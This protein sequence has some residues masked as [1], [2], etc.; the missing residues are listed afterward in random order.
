MII[1]L[2]CSI[3]YIL[4][5]ISL[6]VKYLF[7]NREM[8]IE[9]YKDFLTSEAALRITYISSQNRVKWKKLYTLDTRIKSIGTAL[10]SVLSILIVLYGIDAT[11]NFYLF[12]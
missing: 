1:T 2:I 5:S 11:K 9:D 4:L 10:L 7:L 12:L 8:K 6:L 3:G